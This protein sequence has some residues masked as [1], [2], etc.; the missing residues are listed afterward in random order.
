MQVLIGYLCEKCK[1]AMIVAKGKT[2]VSCSRVRGHCLSKN[3]LTDIKS[4][5]TLLLGGNF[6]GY[7]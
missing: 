5:Q 3:G 1:L 2:N 6:M 7:S 4:N